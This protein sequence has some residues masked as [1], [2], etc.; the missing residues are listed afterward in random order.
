MTS[1]L[2]GFL[3]GGVFL[4]GAAAPRIQK[5]RRSWF[6]DLHPKIL[7]SPKTKTLVLSMN[8]WLLNGDPHNGLL[9]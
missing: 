5:N 6:R 8:Q 1:Y 2:V 3:L 7:E 4:P 9:L